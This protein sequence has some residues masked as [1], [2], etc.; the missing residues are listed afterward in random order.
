MAK[1]LRLHKGS[2]TIVDWQE[3]VSIGPD[4]IK[5]IKD[6]EDGNAKKEITSIPSPFA[7]IDLVKTA[8]AEVVN[9][10]S[11][12]LDGKSVAG[13]RKST[14][15]HKMVSDSLD[16]GEIFFNYNK[17]KDKIQILIWD[18][19]RDLDLLL[20]SN[21]PAHRS[22][23]KTLD[24]FLK[25]DSHPD[26]MIDSRMYNF[27]KMQC[28]Y[29]LNYIGDNKPSTMNIIGATSPCT[30][31]FSSA[32]DLSYVS[33]NICFD[34][35]D[36]PFDD[37][38]RP[39][40]QRDL[41]F[42]KYLW[43]F[44]C[45]YPDFARDF[46]S[47]NQYLESTYNR[48]SDDAKRVLDKVDENS[49]SN[50]DVINVSSA[51]NRV[52]VLGYPLHLRPTQ[53]VIQSDFEIDSQIY[54]DKKPLVLP[55]GSGQ[56]YKP[57]IYTQ[58]EWGEYNKAPVFDPDQWKERTLPIVG[59]VYPYLTISDFLEDTIVRMP[60]KLNSNFYFDG[61]LPK[62]D[63]IKKPSYLLPLSN[64]FFEFFS[65]D[66]LMGEVH[67]GKKMIELKENAGGVSVTLRIPIRGK[68][69]IK[70]IEYQRVY[71]ENSS[72][73]LSKN[74]GA[75]VMKKIG[76][77][78]F[79]AIKFHETERPHYRI[80]L[81][82]QSG[83]TS[84]NCYDGVGLVNRKAFVVRREKGAVCSVETYVVDRSIDRILVQVSENRGFIIPILKSQSGPAQFTFAVD[85][86]TTN[87]HIEY[88]KDGCPSKAFDITPSDIQLQ[89]LHPNYFQDGLELGSAFEDNFIPDI[90][91]SECDYKFPI[92]TA[93]AEWNRIDYS[94]PIF[95]IA[96]GNI[97]FRYEKAK[98]PNHNNI[99]TEL[100]WSTLRKDQV[101]LFLENI[102]LLLRNKVLLNG[103]SLSSTKIIWFYPASM[104]E[105]HCNSF[106]NIWQ[107]L[108]REYFGDESSN[109]ISMS[110]SVAP[111]NFY[112]KKLGAKAN[113]VTIDV[114]GETSDVYVVENSE[115]KL[116]S[117]FRFA[118]NAIF[119]DGYNW[120]SDNN[121]FVK[122][123]S[124][125]IE[126]SLM[127]NGLLDLHEALRSIN[128]TKNSRD[129]T[130]FF[131]ALSKNKVIKDENIPSL[132]FIEKLDGNEQIKH[133]FIIFYSSILY[134]VAKLMKAKG[135]E[136]PL[137]IAFS[138]NGSKTLRVLSSDK[139]TLTSYVK[140]IFEK[141]YNR[142]YDRSNELEIIFN[143]E[144]PKEATCKGGVLSPIAQNFESI[145]NIKCSLLGTDPETLTEK[146]S[147]SSIDYKSMQ[148][149]VNEV[150]NCINFIFT[151]QE[152]CGFFTK[153]FNA[154]ARIAKQVKDICQK[155]LMEYMKLG[156]E[157]RKEEMNSWGA[158]NIVNETLFFLPLVGVLNNLAREISNLKNYSDEYK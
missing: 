16:V 24:V 41:E 5:D 72:P 10:E 46:D 6:P 98:L 154:D 40:Y 55:I 88:S 62:T 141:V 33:K 35:Q 7:R 22:L 3:S 8:Y 106:M 78:L 63:D 137:T 89:R 152:E 32:N 150:K 44:K 21:N 92:R 124:E 148:N 48:L 69:N 14:I 73:D 105:A 146:Q 79:P 83:R 67:G 143:V 138:G 94:K 126:K 125:E 38:Y 77:G 85:F 4:S 95:A 68:G 12:D 142:E 15:Y 80:A 115:P 111:Y 2:D 104:T 110:E 156:L 122:I 116:L 42:I 61:N 37:D 135:L 107:T 23:G 158:G 133:V 39:L 100:K 59:G 82:D 90:I 17:L 70:F 52:E 120:D 81:L 108:Y 114:G 118:S 139:S 93:L 30:L 87:T 75:L 34:G 47:F 51:E 50:Y 140:L 101:K 45:S 129:I 53:D 136:L 60:Y 65:V 20:S 57:L 9:N 96:S 64:L 128:N 36:R 117:S 112:S 134:Y 71:F 56:T 109:L 28:I 66:D 74:S 29:L 1:V 43:A 153:K 84:L 99:K 58:G 157:R 13:K 132:D 102:F 149:I 26:Q 25:Q 151:M 49:I 19:R 31:F 121:G 145:E 91:G 127:N 131:F 54:Q 123:Y 130:S 103:G 113:V 97:P 147:I 27:N 76:I 119:G 86:G 11:F 18:K 155:N 144:N